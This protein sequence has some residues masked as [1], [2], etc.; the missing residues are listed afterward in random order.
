MNV[1]ELKPCPFCGDKA[2]IMWDASEK[3]VIVRCEKCG[4]QTRTYKNIYGSIKHPLMW[5]IARWNQ[6][7]DGGEYN[8]TAK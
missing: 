5:A 1:F 6:R 7:I 3:G 8:G 2:D 4:I